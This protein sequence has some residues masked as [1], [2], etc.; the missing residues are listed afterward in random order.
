MPSIAFDL[1]VYPAKSEKKKNFGWVYES[2]AVR[3]QEK[4]SPRIGPTRLDTTNYDVDKL[5]SRTIQRLIHRAS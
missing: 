2:M 1:G 5:V 3:P 4:K